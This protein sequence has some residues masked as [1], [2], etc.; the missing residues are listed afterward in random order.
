M[1][2]IDTAWKSTKRTTI[3]TQLFDITTASAA[4]VATMRP[5][6]IM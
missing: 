2:G 4:V 6:L 3:P 1:S 5:P